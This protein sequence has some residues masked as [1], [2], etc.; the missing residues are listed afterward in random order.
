MMRHDAAIDAARRNL[1]DMMLTEMIARTLKNILRR[2]QR[3][4]MKNHQSTSEH[5]MRELGEEHERGEDFQSLSADWRPVPFLI[6]DW[7]MAFV[8]F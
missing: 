5:G 6:A 7:H 2:F 4:W 1:R 8:G 3:V